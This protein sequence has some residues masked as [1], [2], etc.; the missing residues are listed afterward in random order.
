MKISTKINHFLTF[1]I[2]S[3][4]AL[5]ILSLF[6][7]LVNGMTKKNYTKIMDKTCECSASQ[8]YYYLI[9]HNDKKGK[10]PISKKYASDFVKT[11]IKEANK[12]GVR[13]DVAF[14]IMMHETGYLNFKGDVKKSQNNFAGLGTTGGGVRGAK[15]KTMEIG[16][17]AVIQHLKCYAS[18][19][20]L[21]EKC[22]DPRWNDALRNKAIYVEYLGYKDNPYKKG[23]A[24]PGK[25]YGKTVLK[26]LNRIK[27]IDTSKIDMSNI[28]ENEDTYLKA[29]PAKVVKTSL[30]IVFNILLIYLLLL[31]LYKLK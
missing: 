25:G 8:M 22:V 3:L 2:I 14:S 19:E 17:R 6:S 18:D 23:W 9:T 21:K 7:D 5:L 12:E 20:P 24:Y 13:A 1:I 28:S 27:K 4:I 11:T 16:I 31:I 10:N 15:F 26:H 30:S 29:S